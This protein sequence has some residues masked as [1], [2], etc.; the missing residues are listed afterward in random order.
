MPEMKYVREASYRSDLFT[1]VQHP[2]T[3]VIIL[4]RSIQKVLIASVD[5]QEQL[6]IKTEITAPD[7]IVVNLIAVHK[8]PEKRVFYLDSFFNLA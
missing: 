4:K 8:P 1:L 6:S 3:Q 7:A 5:V 2:D